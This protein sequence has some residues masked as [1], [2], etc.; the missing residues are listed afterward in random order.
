MNMNHDVN[1]NQV[2]WLLIRLL[3]NMELREM[4]DS[5]APLHSQIVVERDPNDLILLT[6]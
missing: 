1:V 5:Y 6:S 4:L 3:I 2:N